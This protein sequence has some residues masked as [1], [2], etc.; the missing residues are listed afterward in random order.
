[1]LKI[2]VVSD[3]HIQDL[4]RGAKLA[5]ALLGK[6][7]NDV[8]MILHAGDVVNP[9]FLDL[10][11][12]IP[13]YA[14]RGNMDPPMVGVPPRRVLTAEGFRIG[15]IHGW[16]S[17]TSLE[18]QVLQEFHGQSL[19]CL[20]YGHSHVPVCRRTQGLLLFN[21]GSAADRRGEP[22]HTIGI[23]EIGETIEGHIISID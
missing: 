12:D 23:L 5:D 6:W 14:V 22:V 18:Q 15:L 11:G 16:G 3:T 13:V 19:D 2:G 20:V 17:L 4:R 21:P 9:G 8:D 10:F 7:F 1:M